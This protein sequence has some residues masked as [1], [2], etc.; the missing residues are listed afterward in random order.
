MTTIRPME[1]WVPFV[2]QNNSGEE[3]PPFACMELQYSYESDRS[4]TSIDDDDTI[5][6]IV[7]PTTLSVDD[8]GLV[9]FNGPIKIPA[10]GTG[11]GFAEPI[12]LVL[13]DNT[14][15][16]DADPG[17]EIGPIEDSWLMGTNGFG[18]EV[19]SYDTPQ[20]Y[21]VASDERTIYVRRKASGEASRFFVTLED[22]V[23]NGPVY[24]DWVTR[25]IDTSRGVN[26]IYSYDNIVSGAPAGYKC[27]CTRI[28][29]QWVVT[30]G[31]CVVSCS[32]NGSISAGTI[33]SGEVG[34]SYSGTPGSSNITGSTW[35]HSNLPPGLLASGVDGSLSGTP[36][37]AGTYYTVFSA[38][39]PGTGPDSGSDCTITK[40]IPITINEAP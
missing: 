16:G 39:S 28:D 21:Y 38:E 3:V 10:D 35:S 12:G 26:Q 14:E 13:F 36:T 30:F 37:T 20:A 19:F 7:K 2:V 27:I 6:E 1:L 4:A 22:F 11:Q 32:S 17:E 34:S 9:L 33:G 24:A 29:N 8:P 23:G 15:S 18:W 31:P 40:V 5:F 25:T